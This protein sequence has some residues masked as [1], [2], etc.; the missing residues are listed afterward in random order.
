MW[1]LMWQEMRNVYLTST[2][3]SAAPLIVFAYL[4]CLTL[5]LAA[6]HNEFGG[7]MRHLFRGLGQV[8]EV[9]LQAR[10]PYAARMEKPYALRDYIGHFLRHNLTVDLSERRFKA[11]GN[12]VPSIDPI[13]E[14]FTPTVLRSV[15]ITTE[16]DAQMAEYAGIMQLSKRDVVQVA[17]TL[18]WQR[19]RQLDR[20]W[21]LNMKRDLAIKRRG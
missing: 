2:D 3:V 8:R 9:V 14:G 21:S 18:G 17:V 15:R 5:A 19:R 12:S 13:V 20:P 11:M 10:I 7:L 1:Q 4:H 16:M 6:S